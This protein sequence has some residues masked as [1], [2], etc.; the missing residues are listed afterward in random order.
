MFR[1]FKI[2]FY[3]F[4]LKCHLK[5]TDQIQ[6]ANLFDNELL[7]IIFYLLQEAWQKSDKLMSWRRHGGGSGSSI[8]SGDKWKPFLA[9]PSG[10]WVALSVALTGG[11]LS[12]APESPHMLFSLDYLNGLPL[13][14][15]SLGW[16]LCHSRSNRDVLLSSK[17]LGSLVCSSSNMSYTEL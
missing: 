15:L 3:V 12:P 2:T 7:L 5:L 9:L 6:N 14:F 11:A 13:F 16:C 17:P 4:L 1:V 8:H 10:T